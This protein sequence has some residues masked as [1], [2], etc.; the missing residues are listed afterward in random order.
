MEKL[1]GIF[2]LT[3]TFFSFGFTVFFMPYQVYEVF[4]SSYSEVIEAE[5][6]YSK[7]YRHAD[8]GFNKK[9]CIIEVALKILSNKENITIND[10]KS[11]DISTCNSDEAYANKYK[12]GDFVTVYLSKG[13]KYYL[14][15]GSYTEALTPTFFS[16]IWFVVLYGYIKKQRKLDTNSD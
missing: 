7:F 5:V 9:G 3:F 13:G 14:S 10:V 2:I 1:K 16:L 8:V 6:I 15:L 4:S 12:A 11:G